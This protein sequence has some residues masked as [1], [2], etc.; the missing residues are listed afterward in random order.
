MTVFP[1]DKEV[2]IAVVPVGSPL[3]EACEVVAETFREAFETTVAVGQSVDPPSNL[4][5]EDYVLEDW[6]ASLDPYEDEADLLVGVSDAH[7]RYPNRKELSRLWVNRD[8]GRRGVLSTVFTGDGRLT[9]TDR[10]HLSKLS[11]VV[12]GRLFGLH[13]LHREEDLPPCVL[14]VED[15]SRDERLDDASRDERL[16]DVPDTYCDDCWQALTDAK[17]YPKPPE[18]DGW[19]IRTRDDEVVQTAVRWASGDTTWRDYPLMALGFVVVAVQS[20]WKRLRAA[21]IPEDLSARDFP[22]FVHELYRTTRFWG[23]IVLYLAALG[24]SIWVLGSGYE[25]I[26]GSA[27]S[28][29]AL[30]G[31]FVAGVVL[32]LPLVWIVKGVFL[33]LYAAVRG[34]DP[35]EV[36]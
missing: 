32:A 6:L 21:L 36:E 29:G 30:V 16:D 27:P 23:N 26:V 15:A 20:A 9:A 14:D 22:E 31:L 4:D 1:H 11:L 33:G 17:S 12:A 34:L 8:E 13:R 28:D 3:S 2:R 10:E 7:I 25:L 35:E 5:S 24:V 18:P 19:I